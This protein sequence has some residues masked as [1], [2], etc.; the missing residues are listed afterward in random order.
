MEYHYRN[1]KISV[2]KVLPCCLDVGVD[3]N[4]SVKDSSK[5]L[6]YGGLLGAETNSCHL[7]S[8]DSSNLASDLS[9]L[10]SSH[11]RLF[12]ESHALN[13]ATVNAEYNGDKEK[14]KKQLS[15]SRATNANGYL[16]SE[17]AAEILCRG[18]QKQKPLRSTTNG[19]VPK[20]SQMSVHSR[21]Y[22]LELHRDV[23]ENNLE[24]L[25]EVWRKNKYVGISSCPSFV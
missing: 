12:S 19:V 22:C 14:H 3:A 16:N 8:S 2:S 18:D 7:H 9:S 5:R 21:S 23:F 11:A 6:L 4:T 15:T 20:M 17:H 1:V 10:C 13:G 25:D 24:K